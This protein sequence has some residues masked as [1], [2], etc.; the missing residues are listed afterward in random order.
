MMR[1]KQ[2]LI[3]L[4]LVSMTGFMSGG[5]AHPQRAPFPL[6][7]V[8]SEKAISGP[9]QALT[10]K[11]QPFSFLG[12]YKTQYQDTDPQNSRITEK[13]HKRTRESKAL[14]IPEHLELTQLFFYSD[15]FQCIYADRDIHS[16]DIVHHLLRGPPVYC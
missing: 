6:N 4:F 10:Q 12:L 2:Y 9:G 13:R 1:E 8:Q 14:F 15:N 7:L 16:P 5:Y 3:I 11:G